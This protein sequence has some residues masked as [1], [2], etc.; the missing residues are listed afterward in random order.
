[1]SN[2]RL[3]TFHRSALDKTAG[4]DVQPRLQLSTHDGVGRIELFAGDTLLECLDV[5]SGPHGEACMVLDHVHAS[6]SKSFGPLVAKFV[7]H[8][9]RIFPVVSNKALMHYSR[10]F[11]AVLRGP[12]SALR[13]TNVVVVEPTAVPA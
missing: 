11:N 2:A 9:W 13:F 7:G 10:R 12:I 6:T 4:L 3:K 1:M 8:T 5:K